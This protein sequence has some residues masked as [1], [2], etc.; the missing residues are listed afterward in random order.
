MKLDK[1]PEASFLNRLYRLG[2]NLVKWNADRISH[3][4]ENYF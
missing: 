3:L 2:Y 1:H 4:L